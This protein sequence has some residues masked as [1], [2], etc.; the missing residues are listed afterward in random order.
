MTSC[1]NGS[2]LPS[3]N[4]ST[5]LM[6]ASAPTISLLSEK[7]E[8]LDIDINTGLPKLPVELPDSFV[9]YNRNMEGSRKATYHTELANSVKKQVSVCVGR[10]ERVYTHTSLISFL[11]CCEEL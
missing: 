7:G 3:T 8:S 5:K 9:D 2:S 6:S 4:N 11:A 10:G 1:E